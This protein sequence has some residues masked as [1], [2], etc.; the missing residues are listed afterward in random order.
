VR[1]AKD[2]VDGIVNSSRIPALKR[3]QDIQ[4]ELHSHIEDFVAAARAAGRSQDEIERLVLTNFGEPEQIAREFAWV[5]RHER[6]RVRALALALSTLLLAS[7]LSAAVLAAQAALAFGLG[8]P[9]MSVLASPHTVIEALDILAF[10]ATYLG[11]TSLEKVF[12]TYRFPKAAF[13]IMVILAVLAVASAATDLRIPLPILG[14]VSGILFRAVQLYV[15]PA[16][17]RVGIVVIL[18]PLA[19]VIL[20]LVRWPAPPAALAATY[21]SWLVL[22]AAYQLVTQVAARVDTAL[23]NGLQKVRESY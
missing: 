8:T 11:I 14:L 5:Y 21:A 2:L 3:R 7:G 9:V 19:G 23:L 22:G 10:V 20:T 18:F 6:H 13:L 15:T 12:A 4:R 16:L 17:A 1:A